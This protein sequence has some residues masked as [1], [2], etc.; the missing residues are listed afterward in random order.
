MISLIFNTSSDPS[1]GKRKPERWFEPA[2][3]DDFEQPMPA[4]WEGR[5]QQV[6]R[7]GPK[8]PA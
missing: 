2:A 3:K 4:E 5:L 7:V 1:I 8:V 6:K